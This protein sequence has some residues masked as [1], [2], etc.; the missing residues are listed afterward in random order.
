MNPLIRVADPSPVANG[1]VKTIGDH[2]QWLKGAGAPSALVL[3][4][5]SQG[6]PVTSVASGPFFCVHRSGGHRLVGVEVTGSL[7][8]I[9][10]GAI[11]R[12]FEMETGF[13]VMGLIGCLVL[14]LGYK[15]FYKP[16]FGMPVKRRLLSRQM[17]VRRDQFAEVPLWWSDLQ[18]Q[19][20]IR[21]HWK[22]SLRRNVVRRGPGPA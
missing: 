7:Q 8:R 10:A 17:Q 5:P 13:A 14:Y 4:L 1:A 15:L 9:A 20:A 21:G 12:I 3:A 19:R 16:D 6:P 2:D 18:V 11:Y 22:E